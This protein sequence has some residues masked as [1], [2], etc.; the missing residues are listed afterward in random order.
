MLECESDDEFDG[1]IDENYDSDENEVEFEVT[2]IDN[3][4]EIDELCEE[5]E[6]TT[7]TV[8]LDSSNNVS[9]DAIESSIS[10]C[11]EYGSS[12]S[13]A[14]LSPEYSASNSSPSSPGC[15]VGYVWQRPGRISTAFSNRQLAEENC[16]RNH[17][18]SQMSCHPIPE[19]FDDGNLAAWTK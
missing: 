14:Y 11:P 8:C 18:S 4:I 16:R 5:I 17:L 2:D 7:T 19:E 15:T 13:S 12:G 1:Y 3:G 10:S 6:Y 9:L